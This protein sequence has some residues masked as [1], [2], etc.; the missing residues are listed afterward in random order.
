MNNQPENKPSKADHPVKILLWCTVAMVVLLI[1][2]FI[3]YKL[4]SVIYGIILM[5]CGVCSVVLALTVFWRCPKCDEQL[6]MKIIFGK[7]VC[8]F[9]G[10]E[11]D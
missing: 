1:A 6:P 11:L 10:N 2:G 5:S 4:G 8:P 3:V 9:C 7:K